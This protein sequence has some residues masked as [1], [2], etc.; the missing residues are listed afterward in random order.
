MGILHL[1]L[2]A[3]IYTTCSMTTQTTCISQ[4]LPP[5]A[6]DVHQVRDI[7]GINCSTILIPVFSEGEQCPLLHDYLQTDNKFKDYFFPYLHSL[8]SP[9][10]KEP[11]GVFI[12]DLG[13]SFILVSFPAPIYSQSTIVHRAMLS[14]ANGMLNANL[15]SVET[16][17]IVYPGPFFCTSDFAEAFYNGLFVRFMEKVIQQKQTFVLKEIHIYI[18]SD[19]IFESLPRD[20]VELG[21]KLLLGDAKEQ[22][23]CSQCELNPRTDTRLCKQCIDSY[24][25][26]KILVKSK[27]C[28]PKKDPKPSDTSTRSLEKESE[29]H[30]AES[31]RYIRKDLKIKFA[32]HHADRY[33]GERL[34]SFLRLKLNISSD[35]VHKY[36]RFWLIGYTAGSFI[37]GLVPKFSM[38][39]DGVCS[40]AAGMGAGAALCSCVLC[41]EQLVKLLK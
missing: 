4:F 20:L 14:L 36:S 41:K 9:S 26:E 15:N 2:F 3:P 13:K 38:V 16:L 11:E 12:E 22:L 32:D 25:E 39:P 6:L 37:G 33:L 40:V 35:K 8:S 28:P 23:L 34:H 30:L 5:L 29:K 18:Q 21:E 24:P 7:A 17:G 31:F 10:R 27:P 19:S 1:C